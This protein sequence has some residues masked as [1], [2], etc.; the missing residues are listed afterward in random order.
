MI[1]WMVTIAACLVSLLVGIVV[2][3]FAVAS[4]VGSKLEKLGL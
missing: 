4:Y 3:G 1:W 2:G